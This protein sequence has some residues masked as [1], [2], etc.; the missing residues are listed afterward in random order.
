MASAARKDFER[1]ERFE[2]AFNR[3]LVS[4]SMRIESVSFML[5]PLVYILAQ[6]PTPL[7][8]RRSHEC[9]RG[10]Q[11]CVRYGSSRFGIKWRKQDRRCLQALPGFLNNGIISSPAITAHT[12]EPSHRSEE[13]RVGKECRS[14]W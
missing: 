7:N 13:R 4:G 11:E 2:S 8:P 14:R 6:A 3:F 12:M 5:C 10:T 1:L 9:E